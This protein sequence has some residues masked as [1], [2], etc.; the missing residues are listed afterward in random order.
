MAGVS[1]QSIWN[2][3]VT[4][5]LGFSIALRGNRDEYKSR[6]GLDVVGVSI[7]SI[8]NARVT[9]FVELLIALRGNRDE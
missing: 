3:R 8:W 2:A 6:L 4:C 1:I 7:Q 9:S 5:S